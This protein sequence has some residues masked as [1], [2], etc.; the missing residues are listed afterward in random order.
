M[1]QLRD[2][3]VVVDWALPKNKYQND[4]NSNVSDNAEIKEEVEGDAEIKE[5]TISD[6]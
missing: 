6:E 1:K 4:A 5:E 3:T 2:R